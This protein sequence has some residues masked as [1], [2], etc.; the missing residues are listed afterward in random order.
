MKMAN[1][2]SKSSTF[3]SGMRK[4]EDVV[5]EQKRKEL[6]KKRELN[7]FLVGQITRDSTCYAVNLKSYR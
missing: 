6:E 3:G 5:R 4:P 7:D 1:Q 2:N